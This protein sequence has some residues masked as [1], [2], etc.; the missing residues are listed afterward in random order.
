MTQRVMEWGD[1][2]ELTNRQQANRFVDFVAT[3]IK[4]QL[5]HLAGFDD[6]KPF[7]LSWKVQQ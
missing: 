7:T 5:P 4:E 1:Y 6:T 2:I 3:Q